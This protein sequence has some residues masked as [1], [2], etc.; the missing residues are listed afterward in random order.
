MG[1]SGVKM[2]LKAVGAFQYHFNSQESTLTV[3][4]SLK[5][6]ISVNEI[7]SRPRNTRIISGLYSS[8]HLLDLTQGILRRDAQLARLVG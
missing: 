4:L 5:G 7:A 1:I 8:S 2:F 6:L 3:L